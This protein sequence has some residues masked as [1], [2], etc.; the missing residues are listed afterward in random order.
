MNAHAEVSDRGRPHRPPGLNEN[1]RT[2]RRLHIHDLRDL[3]AVPLHTLRW[4]CRA[5]TL[6][7][8]LFTVLLW[9][10]L[11]SQNPERLPCLP[12]AL[13]AWL[14]LTQVLCSVRGNTTKLLSGEFSFPLLVPHAQKE[15]GQQREQI[16]E[17]EPE[18]DNQARRA[19]AEIWGRKQHNRLMSVTRS[20][21]LNTES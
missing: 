16:A 17:E 19:G 9:T 21:R 13:S 20:A 18:R 3:G 10:A 5:V 11:P 6:G 4:L 12:S 2:A 14:V 15:S 1:C 8:P 7:D